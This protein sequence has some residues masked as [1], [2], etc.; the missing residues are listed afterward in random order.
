MKL[1]G[2]KAEWILWGVGAGVA[3]V[4]LNS[5]LSGRLA[6]SAGEAAGRLPVDVFTGGMEGLFGLPDTRSADSVNRCQ[7]ARAAGDDWAASFYCPASDWF[8]GLFDGK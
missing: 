4:A 1:P 7:E 2:I 5:V 3:L 8:R 6:T